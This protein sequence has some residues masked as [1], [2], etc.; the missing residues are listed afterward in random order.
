LFRLWLGKH[1]VDLGQKAIV[2]FAAAT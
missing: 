2:S 1:T